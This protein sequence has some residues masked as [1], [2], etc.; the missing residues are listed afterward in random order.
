MKLNVQGNYLGLYVNT[1]SIN[2]LKIY[3]N[4][5]IERF[6]FITSEDLSSLNID[7]GKVLV[8]IPHSLTFSVSFS[9]FKNFN[10]FLCAA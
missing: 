10:L 2:K 6:G 4:S 8:Y 7:S 1:E 3:D 5:S 9:I